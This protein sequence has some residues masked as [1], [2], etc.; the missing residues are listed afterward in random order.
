MK[1]RALSLVLSLLLLFTLLPL[2]ARDAQAA[3]GG[4]EYAV[5]GL[6]VVYITQS[7]ESRSTK[8]SSHYG[9][10]AQDMSTGSGNDHTVYAPFTGTIVDVFRK[11]GNSI[12]FESKNEVWF[13][14]GTH[15]YMNVEFTHITD[16]D[17]NAL[18]LY[19]GKEV[20]QG[21][22][23]YKEGTKLG[24]GSSSVGLH[25]HIECARGKYP[26]SRGSNTDKNGKP[27]YWYYGGESGRAAVLKNELEVYDALCLLDDNSLTGGA[28]PFSSTEVK[29][30]YGFE[31]RPYLDD[32]G[33]P[34]RDSDGKLVY[35][36]VRAFKTLSEVAQKVGAASASGGDSADHRSNSA[37]FCPADGSYDASEDRRISCSHSFGKDGICS[38]CGRYDISKDSVSFNSWESVKPRVYRVVSD[39]A[40]LRVAP[41][42]SGE[43]MEYLPAGT[44]VTIDAELQ[45]RAGNTWYVTTNDNR[46]QVYPKNLATTLTGHYE[47]AFIYSENLVYDHD[48]VTLDSPRQQ[49]FTGSNAVIASTVHKPAGAVGQS[50]GI[51]WSVDSEGSIFQR[52]DSTKIEKLS[53]PNSQKW[54]NS[55]SYPLSVDLNREAGLTLESGKTYTIELFVDVDDHRYYSAPVRLVGGTGDGSGFHGIDPQE[56]GGGSSEGSG[57]STEG[58]PAPSG[59]RLSVDRS[60]LPANKY[61]EYV[62]FNLSVQDSL[63]NTIVIRRADGSLETEANI[64]SGSVW[65]YSFDAPGTYTV[66][67]RCENSYGQVSTN[68]LTLTVTSDVSFRTGVSGLDGPIEDIALDACFSYT[69]KTGGYRSFGVILYDEDYRQIGSATDQDFPAEWRT[70]SRSNINAV[71]DIE[72]ELNVA[73]APA[74]V[75]RY[76]IFVDFVS[77]GMIYSEYCSFQTPGRKI[78]VPENLVTNISALTETVGSYVTVSF[79]ADGAE[80][81]RVV[82]TAADGHVVEDNTFGLTTSWFFAL[83]EPG[84]YS[85]FVQAFNAGGTTDG[86]T[87]TLVIRPRDVIWQAQAEL[88]EATEDDAS[89]WV[90]VNYEELVGRGDFGI[91]LFNASGVLLGTATRIGFDDPDGRPHN[92]Y[93]ADEIS[94]RQDLRLVLTPDTEYRYRPFLQIG[95]IRYS[96]QTGTFR[97]AASEPALANPFADVSENDWFYAD[98]CRAYAEGLING[99]S[100][101][102][103]APRDKMTMAEALKLAA[104][105]RQL[106]IDGSVTLKNSSDGS[107]WYMSYYNYLNGL[108]LLQSPS[109][110]YTDFRKPVTR[111]EMARIFFSAVPGSALRAR[112]TIPTGSIPDVDTRNPDHLMF[113]TAV[114]ALYQAGILAGSDAY[115]TFHPDRDIARSEVA[116]ILVRLID[117]TARVK[118]PARLGQ[119]P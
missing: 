8:G 116:A 90:S 18:G 31:Y 103:F 74:A 50:F 29:K 95:D 70:D 67:A 59:A 15:D 41:Y 98:V 2:G 88:I 111:G 73:L 91:E 7:L 10:W 93:Q 102:N 54:M 11:D 107:P 56:E 26:G 109:I 72:T 81:F 47:E 66:Y 57:G 97:T 115:G 86:P 36:D 108:G 27:V 99:K 45:N 46:Y 87:Y 3:D 6:P 33:D 92:A 118:A 105:V 78:T 16:A 71:F 55:T 52:M 110:A 13:A 84:T 85:V 20:R 22:P 58:R 89:F 24:D 69:G 79:A 23:L 38:R 5:L 80:G 117:P 19:K 113:S 4:Y 17:Y 60:S 9:Y 114:Y 42:A 12:I 96:G 61:V 49:S 82:V 94:V 104:C 48:L 100:A 119:Q 43:V 83:D 75:Y 32:M 65:Q 40:P 30:W 51:R 39:G 64:G 37:G 112:N 35:T 63:V 101:T 68:T 1:H 14:D 21:Q 62:T 28:F 53:D 77:G 76:R 106:L 44:L 25:V 34:V